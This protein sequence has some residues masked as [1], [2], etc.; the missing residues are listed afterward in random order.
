MAFTS[1][2]LCDPFQLPSYVGMAFLYGTIGINKA[3]ALRW[4]ENYKRAE[5]RLLSAPD[6]D[7]AWQHRGLKISITHPREARN[8]FNKA[9][10]DLSDE[11]D[12]PMREMID[13]LEQ[14]LLHLK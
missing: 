1:A 9:S 6:Q 4:C 8:L 11:R 14:E 13:G 12:A 10:G 7:L 2:I 5:A 3:V